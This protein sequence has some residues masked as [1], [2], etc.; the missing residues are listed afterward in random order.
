D[1]I[2]AD[3]E[4]ARL[5]AIFDDTYAREMSFKLTTISL[6]MEEIYDTSKSKTMKDFLIKTDENL[7]PIKQQLDEFNGTTR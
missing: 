6:L 1:P 7:Q 5:N 4:D 3:L 2:T